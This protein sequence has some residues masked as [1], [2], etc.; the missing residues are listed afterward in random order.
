MRLRLRNHLTWILKLSTHLDLLYR[1][2]E[3]HDNSNI[4][5]ID[6]ILTDDEWIFILIA[7]FTARG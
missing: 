6:H 1:F 5:L 7:L 4:F 3:K 2:T